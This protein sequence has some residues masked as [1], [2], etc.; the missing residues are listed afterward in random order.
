V[1]RYPSPC[2]PEQVAELVAKYFADP[3]RLARLAQNVQRAIRNLFAI[4]VQ[5]TPRL[6]LLSDLLAGT[7][8]D[9]PN[10]R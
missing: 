10:G 2:E 3:E 8:A 1:Y 4:D 7:S 9:G 6:R 5:M